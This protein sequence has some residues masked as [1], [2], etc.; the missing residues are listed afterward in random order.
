MQIF[1]LFDPFVFNKVLKLAKDT[2][3]QA[4]AKKKG[5]AMP[6]EDGEDAMD[7]DEEEAA[8]QPEDSA[9][10]EG[11]CLGL[12]QDMAVFLRVMVLS[13]LPDAKRSIAEALVD[14][15]RAATGSNKVPP[16]PPPY[17][18]STISSPSAMLCLT[19]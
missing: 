4:G 7:E 13:E 10:L 5:S 9:K 8:E 15:T 16:P 17:P 11:W 3:C 6:G 14:I 12:M 2:L 18:H 19:S 1:S